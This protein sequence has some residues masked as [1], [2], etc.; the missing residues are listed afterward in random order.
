MAYID[1][2][3]GG[4][5][6]WSTI[7]VVALIQGAVGI[8][9]ING[10][11]VKWIER[12]PP[13]RTEGEQIKLAPLPKPEPSPL[14]PTHPLTRP[15]PAPLPPMAPIGSASPAP[16]PITVPGPIDPGPIAGP[17]YD[18]VP[19]A[20]PTPAFTARSARARNA[21]GSWA[22]TSDYPA[23]DLREGN[24]GVT[25]FLLAIGADGKVQS[26]TI[27]QTSGS[28]SLDKAT[29]DN[30][31]RRARFEPAMDNQ[32]NRTAGTYSGRIRW[33]IPQD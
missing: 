2:R 16:G 7:A 31:A 15:E 19:P 32:G 11:A 33:Q 29:C 10:L 28:P 21:P 24:Q 27:T 6:R 4:Q 12:D 17:I 26:C 14:P 20:P 23:R 30:V 1:Q 13:P 3:T 9:L 22:T 25:A 18:P 8:A 5:Q